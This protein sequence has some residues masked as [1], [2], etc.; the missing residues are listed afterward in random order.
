MHGKWSARRRVHRA[1][2]CLPNSASRS[3]SHLVDHDAI[4]AGVA[5]TER[6]MLGVL[7][8]K[9]ASLFLGLFGG[10]GFDDG[11]VRQPLDDGDAPLAG[12]FLPL[13]YA[14]ASV[15]EGAADSISRRAAAAW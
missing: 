1:V 2:P 4:E 15:W 13:A 14:V 3:G 8:P 5:E 9:L 10:V 11:D 12:R 7:G 6:P